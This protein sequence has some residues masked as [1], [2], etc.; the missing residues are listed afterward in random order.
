MYGFH[1]ITS[2]NN[3][4]VGA[5]HHPNFVKDDQSR[6]LGMFRCNGKKNS[7]YKGCYTTNP[8]FYKQSGSEPRHAADKARAKSIRED[9]KVPSSSY[10]GVSLIQPQS[11]D[12]Q[13][14]NNSGRMNMNSTASVVDRA[15]PR[16]VALE[17]QMNVTTSSSAH[18][19]RSVVSPSIDSTM[20]SISSAWFSSF[21]PDEEISLTTSSS[22]NVNNENTVAAP[23]NDTE[24]STFFEGKMFF[25][26]D[27]IDDSFVW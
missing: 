19:L 13:I 22:C 14:N 23:T 6:C 5:Y 26:V 25:S 8:D 3:P 9:V 2:K 1:R 12:S 21:P 4:D 18:H 11:Q 16:S 20:P 24:P 17:A 10:D 27:P 7:F 15:F